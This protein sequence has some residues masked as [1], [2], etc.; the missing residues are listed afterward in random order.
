MQLW[1]TLEH[2]RQITK[3]T[4]DIAYSFCI[5]IYLMVFPIEILLQEHYKDSSAKVM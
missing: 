4:K 2:H 3:L 1:Y 5:S